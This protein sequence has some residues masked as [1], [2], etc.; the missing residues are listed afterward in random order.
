M[1]RFLLGTAT[2]FA[3]STAMAADDPKKQD[4]PKPPGTAEKKDDTR[5][6]MEKFKAAKK[7]LEEYFAG[8]RKTFT[9]PLSPYGTLFQMKA[10][11]ALEAIPYGET[12]SYLEEATM[13]GNPKAVRAIG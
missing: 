5:T 2:A 13:V 9:L 3:V 12:R 4:P 6:P 11:K 8:R 1:K 10:W 7:E